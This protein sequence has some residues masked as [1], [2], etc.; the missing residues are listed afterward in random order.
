MP[1]SGSS[2]SDPVLEAEL[3]SLERVLRAIAEPAMRRERLLERLEEAGPERGYALVAGALR[4]PG[5]PAPHLPTVREVLL[6]CLREGGAARPLHPGL[7]DALLGEADRRDD[8][9]VRRLLRDAQ[10]VSVL[11][12]PAVQLPRAMAG[13]PLGVRRTL[14]RGLDPHVLERLLL[15]PDPVVIAHLLANPRLTEDHVVRIAARRPVAASTLDVI[16]RSRRFG[17]RPRVR[18]ALARNPYCPADLAIRLLGTLPLA[19]VRAVA[20]DGTLHP[21]TRRHARAELR[22]RRAGHREGD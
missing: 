22:R 11:D 17:G 18:T 20:G 1:W 14:A 16:Q 3:R 15:D 12:D 7:R 13:L 9:F 10:A 6:D 19:E 21:E 8:S 5:D 2:L 4:R